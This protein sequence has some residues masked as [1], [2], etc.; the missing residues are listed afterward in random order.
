M[1]TPSFFLEEND[2]M[3]KNLTHVLRP[4]QCFQLVTNPG[5]S[6]FHFTTYLAFF[7]NLFLKRTRIGKFQKKQLSKQPCNKSCPCA[8]KT[9]ENKE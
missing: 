9:H 4:S 6:S 7:F 3:Y 5:F 2:R 8:R 1:D